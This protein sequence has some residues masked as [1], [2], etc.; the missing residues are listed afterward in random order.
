MPFAP[1]ANPDL[2]G[3]YLYQGITQAGQ[4]IAAGLGDLIENLSKKSKE[5]KAYLGLADAMKESGELSEAQHAALVNADTDTIKGFVDGKKVAAT[6]AKTRQDTAEQRARAALYSQQA[7]DRKT[8]LGNAQVQPEFM[9]AMERYLSPTGG[10]DDA[11][12]TPEGRAA[13]IAGTVQPGP[14]TPLRA[15]ARAARETGYTIKPGQLDDVLRSLKYGQAPT[16]PE[17]FAPTKATVGGVTYEA[18]PAPVTVPP[19]F[20]PTQ[21][22][23]GDD[24]KPRYTLEPT[25]QAP[26]IPPGMQPKTVTVDSKGRPTVS[27]AEPDAAKKLAGDYPW[28][29]DDDMEKFKTGLR[30]VKDPAERNAVIETRNRYETALGRPS[31]LERFLMGETKAGGDGTKP[32]A[33]GTPA[34]KSPDT[35]PPKA[36]VQVPAGRVR[37]ISPDGRIGN[38]PA[39]QLE[40][41]LKNGYR[42]LQ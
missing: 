38:I 4:T 32:A 17:G 41:A 23:I 33:A 39:A 2:A 1:A 30:A 37:V 31:L 27:Y 18:P 6:L 35:T 28:L 36:S 22:V 5:R 10:Y 9:A 7:E 11:S 40:D 29:L 21:I 13:M 8:E 14:M 20:S 42:Q 3:Q 15:V 19:G 34:A 12:Q 26:V 24:G 16:L 25:A